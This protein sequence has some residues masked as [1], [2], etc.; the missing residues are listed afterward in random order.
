[1]NGMAELPPLTAIELDACLDQHWPPPAVVAVS[2]AD[3][4]G[5]QNWE[6]PEHDDAGTIINRWSGL[7][8]CAPFFRIGGTTVLGVEQE[9][10]TVQIYEF[11]R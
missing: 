11:D 4:H 10:G 5:L 1:M 8:G 7:C 9:P 6:Y 2:L 3:F